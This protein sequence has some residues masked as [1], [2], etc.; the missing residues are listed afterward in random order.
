MD[1]LMILVRL[2]LNTNSPD[3]KVI[4]MSATMDSERF[5]NYFHSR[6]VQVPVIN[7]REERN[8][9]LDKRFLDD[10]VD[11]FQN[12]IN[13][14]IPSISERMM[15][16]AVDIIFQHVK[17]DNKS[18]ILVFLPGFYEIENFERVLLHKFD[19]FSNYKLI[20]LHSALPPSNQK[21]AFKQDNQPKII[22][23]TNIAEN[24]VTFPMV[25]VV[26]DFCLTKYLV[27]SKESN[28]ASL[29]LTWTS[30]M[31]SEQR[32]GRTGR[33]CDGIVYHLVTR[34]FYKTEMTQWTEPEMLRVPL[35]RVIL[36]TKLLTNRK[37]K[38]FL[39]G[40]L[41]PPNFENVKNSVLILKAMGALQR[42]GS[43][44]KFTED[45]GDLTYC[46]RILAQLPCD[47]HIGKFIVLGYLFSVLKEAIII[48]AGLNINGS[49][50]KSNYRKRLE[51]YSTRL[52]WSDGSGSD[53]IAIL[54]AYNLWQTTEE[55]ELFK[56]ANVRQNWCDKFNLDLKNL[57]EMKELIDEII[58]RLDENR[59][60]HMV[61]E[62]FRPVLEKEEKTMMLKICAAGK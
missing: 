31:S 52:S 56:N 49:I 5:A 37:P 32:A 2:F 55:N 4:L 47:V 54:N 19:V 10:I 17:K 43:D 27:A 40:A 12:L 38:N 36:K 6:S 58:F 59:M 28:L 9:K 7:M 30:K 35:E 51:S 29:K 45:D 60:W 23:S 44:G 46:G 11:T 21:L 33:V 20:V 39:A 16:L 53:L 34:E 3:T 62:N 41:D 8:F 22:L 18:S 50:F 25:N 1:F 13:F 26:V 14:E 24:S 57:C 15:S 61:R 42:N 48:G